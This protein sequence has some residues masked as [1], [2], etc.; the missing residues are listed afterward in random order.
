MDQIVGDADKVRDMREQL[1]R[2]RTALIANIPNFWSQAICGHNLLCATFKE[3]AEKVEEVVVVANYITIKFNATSAIPFIVKS[4]G[5]PSTAIATGV[6]E[7]DAWMAASGV[8]DFTSLILIHDFWLNPVQ[9]YLAPTIV[10]FEVQEPVYA[11][12]SPLCFESEL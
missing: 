3:L 8:D 10:E 1:M 6:A 12:S 7:F 9:Y 11:P 4:A 2:E 5:G